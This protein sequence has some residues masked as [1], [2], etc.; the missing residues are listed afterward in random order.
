MQL[1]E[2][3]RS[4]ARA[5]NGAVALH[6]ALGH[7]LDLAAA[8]APHSAARAAKALELLLAWTRSSKDPWSASTLSMNGFP[9]ELAFSSADP[10]LRYTA[11][12]ADPA[13]P[14]A[15][16]LKEAVAVLRR[17]D[18]PLPSPAVMDRL[19]RMQGS[20]ALKYGAWLSGRHQPGRDDYKLYAEIP[21]VAAAEADAWSGALL[22]TVPVRPGDEVRIEM[23]GYD[24]GTRRVELYHQVK[25]MHPNGIGLLLRRCGLERRQQE[26]FDLLQECCQ[27]SIR[28]ELP[29]SVFGFSY[30]VPLGGGALRFSLYTFAVALFGGDGFIR[31]KLLDMAARHGWDLAWYSEL[32]AAL[33]GRHGATT[34]HGMLGICAAA[35]GSLQV[36]IGLAPP[37]VSQHD[38]P[39]F[40]L[41]P[42]DARV[43]P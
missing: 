38:L 32:T 23:I 35:T 28:R 31:S 43:Q 22:D 30:S 8:S 24:E 17:L 34:C 9:V 36:T 15:S 19:G 27:L 3:S 26:V 33:R 10:A 12:I 5:G 18:A 14:Q 37:P 21:A 29:S 4:A 1:T 11:E 6:P 7:A 16:R 13:S 40:L 20:Q 41:E 2:Q 39:G 25:N 42:R